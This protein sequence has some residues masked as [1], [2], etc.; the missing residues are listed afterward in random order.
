[1]RK[2][3]EY[4]IREC[5]CFGYI[6]KKALFVVFAA[7]NHAL[8]AY[9]V[10]SDSNC[11]ELGL[12]TLQ[13]PLPSRSRARG[14]NS[15]LLF[16]SSFFSPSSPTTNTHTQASQIYLQNNCQQPQQPNPQRKPLL[17]TDFA[18][19][20]Q[21]SHYLSF[22]SATSTSSQAKMP[23]GKENPSHVVT[24][25]KCGMN[26]NAGGTNSVQDREAASFRY[27]EHMNNHPDIMFGGRHV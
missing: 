13:L 10:S 16:P 26:F 22:K 27:I 17:S 1:M 14:L 25:W 12:A 19:A 4:M 18:S 7:V 8:D 15:C 23:T 6:H 24:C 3:C 21:P 11:R 5:I 9:C 20:H 2:S